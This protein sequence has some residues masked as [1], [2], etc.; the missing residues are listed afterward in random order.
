MLGYLLL[1]TLPLAILMNR[2]LDIQNTRPRIVL[3]EDSS[4]IRLSTRENHHDTMTRIEK[5]KAL[6]DHC[7]GSGNRSRTAEDH[8]QCL[9]TNDEVERFVGMIDSFCDVSTFECHAGL[10]CEIVSIIVTRFKP[11]GTAQHSVVLDAT[12]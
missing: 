1:V 7:S 10:F 3:P 11:Q 6:R 2:Q 5:T 12:L 9:L 4:I 8:I